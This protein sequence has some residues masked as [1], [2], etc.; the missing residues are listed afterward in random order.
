MLKYIVKRLATA[1]VSMFIVITVVFLLMRLMPVEGYFGGRADSMTEENKQKILENMGLL[2]PW[3][4]QLAGFYD[5][6]AHLDFGRSVT[7]Q[8]KTPVTKI[9]AKKMPY[10]IGFG[11]GA[12]AISL[13]LGCSLGV[14]MARRP[15]G[16]WDKL[17]TGY[18]VF[19]NAV[20]PIVYYLMIQISVTAST[21]LPMLFNSAKP[22]SY[23]LPLVCMA[24]GPTANYAMWIR[25]YMVDEL[26]RD[27]IKLA[28]AKG[29]PNNKIML[30]HVVRNAFIPLAQYLPSTILFTISGSIYVEALFSIPGMGGLL[31]QVIKLQDNTMVQALVLIYAA[32]S[33][34]GLLF[35]DLMMALV[36]PRISFTGKE[37][38]R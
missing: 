12:I 37:G 3:Y 34:L 22:E 18:I 9:L 29:M 28:R 1:L 20:P 14:L 11:L 24:L 17:G 5:D 7:L 35:G 4:K 6:L 2:D 33:V 23:V 26:N 32:L 31:I 15:H 13:V 30:R 36:D 19:I 8:P 16:L 38:A 27:Y 10:S 21:P 25:R